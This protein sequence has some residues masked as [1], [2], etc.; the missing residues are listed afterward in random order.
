M[1]IITDPDDLNQGTEVTI[2]PLTKEITLNI[3]GLLSDDGV[4]G[5]ALYSFLKEEWRTDNTLIAYDFPQVSI[6]PEQFEFIDDWKPSNEQTRT[7]IRNAG[8]REIESGGNIKREYTGIVS[9][10]D[11]APADTAYYAFTSDTN[12]IDF[13]FSGPVNQGIQTFGDV[14][15]GNFD[16]RSEELSVFIRTQG[17]LYGLSTTT[18][19]GVSAIS[20]ITYR[21]PLQESDDLKIDVTDNDI[22]TLA[23]YTGMSIAYG[24]ASRVIGSTS[25]DFDVVIEGNGGTAQE[26]YNF[27]QRQLRKPTDIDSNGSG[28][29]GELADALLEFVGDT[30]KTEQGVYIDNFDASDTNNIIFTDDTGAEITFP[31]VSTGRI[32]FNVNL[33]NDP[34]AVF[35]LFFLDTFGSSSAE[36]VN[37][38]DGNPISGDVNG[39]DRLSFTYDYDGN[40]QGGRTPGT[41]RPV[42]AVAIGE[43]AAQYVQAQGAIIRASD[44]VLSLVSALERN[45]ANP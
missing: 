23:P 16:K 6:T 14:A 17:K 43:D 24:P 8:W 30:L 34:D 13:D 3:A 28:V 41:D 11:I 27:V 22:D 9:L 12:K 21:F 40:N 31:F 18:D 5:Q 37:D 39:S 36:I 20:S 38:N 42:I 35:R 32:V 44:Q 2:N 4:T 19:I 29:I 10:G 26:I 7:L 33:Q 15:N 45:Y 1:A 25:Y